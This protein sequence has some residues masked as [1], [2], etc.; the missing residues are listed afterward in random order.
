MVL[1]VA[2]RLQNV[3]LL[4]ALVPLRLPEI[5]L[6]LVA[7]LA[8]QR[9]VAALVDLLLNQLKM[10][11]LLYYFLRCLTFLLKKPLIPESYFQERL[12]ACRYHE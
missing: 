5:Q 3:M 7:V 6:Q 8:D 2:L 11:F 4:L 1:F 9:L 10:C 12:L